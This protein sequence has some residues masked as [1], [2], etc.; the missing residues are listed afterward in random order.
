MD[1]DLLLLFFTATSCSI[2]VYLIWRS[3][4]DNNPSLRGEC[5]F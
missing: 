4:I 5:D 3:D 1:N 2:M